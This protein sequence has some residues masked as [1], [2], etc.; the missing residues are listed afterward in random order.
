MDCL[1]FQCLNKLN[2]SS[3]CLFGLT[4]HSAASYWRESDR[5]WAGKRKWRQYYSWRI[6]RAEKYPDCGHQRIFCERWKA[7]RWGAWYYDGK[8]IER[9]FTG[10]NCV[11]VE[12]SRVDH[13]PI[14]GSQISQRGV[15][16]DGWPLNKLL[17]FDGWLWNNKITMSVHFKV[18]G[19]AGLSAIA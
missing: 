15:T 7:A 10:V 18:R 14:I 16:L 11:R 5:L 4:R 17:P 3:L 2:H 19:V 8:V 13:G 12:Q 1:S 6:L 9:Y